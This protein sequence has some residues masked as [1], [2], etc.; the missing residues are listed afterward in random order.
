MSPPCPTMSPCLLPRFQLAMD[1]PGHPCP[2][3][4]QGRSPGGSQCRPRKS[5]AE[6]FSNKPRFETL[7]FSVARHHRVPTRRSVSRT[8]RAVPRRCRTWRRKRLATAMSRHESSGS[9]AA[10]L[11]RRADCHLRPRIPTSVGFRTKR[12]CAGE[13]RCPG[14]RERE[15]GLSSSLQTRTTGLQNGGPW[16]RQRG[17]M[18]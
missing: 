13:G 18:V 10:A 4:T 11:Q 2:L 15:A 1:S 6:A 17:S 16:H 14:R 8:Q 7:E 9:L 12:P 5:Q 3:W